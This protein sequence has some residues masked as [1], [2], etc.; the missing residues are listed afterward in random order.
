MARRSR[1]VRP[2]FGWFLLLDGGLAALAVLAASDGAH[3]AADEALPS[4]LPPRPALQRL[5]VAA[6]ITHLFEAMVARRMARRRGLRSGAWTRQTLVVG[7]PSILKLRQI[8]KP[9]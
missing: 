3:Q 4:A 6:V 1:I 2:S 8:P 9:G 7:F 5:F